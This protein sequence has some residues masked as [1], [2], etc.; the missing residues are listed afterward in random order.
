MLS[1]PPA[2]TALVVLLQL[3]LELREG[4]TLVAA[5]LLLPPELLL[6]GLRDILEYTV[7]A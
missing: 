4:A 6:A 5:A 1:S 3:P 2:E 7:G